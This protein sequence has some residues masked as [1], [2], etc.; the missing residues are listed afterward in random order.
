M[1]DLKNTE[2]L[3]SSGLGAFIS[4]IAACRSNQGDI[5]LAAPSEYIRSLLN[6]THLNKVLKSFDNVKAAVENFKK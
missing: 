3:D 2:Y 1:L 5:Y 6:I 4:Q